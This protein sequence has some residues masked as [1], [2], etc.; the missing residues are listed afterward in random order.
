MAHSLPAR[1]ACAAPL[2]GG[3]ILIPGPGGRLQPLNDLLRRLRMLPR[4]CSPGENPLDGFGQ[5]QPT[6]PQRRVQRHDPVLPQPAEQLRRVMPRQVVPD[7]QHPQRRQLVQKRETEGEPVL[8][9]LPRGTDLLGGEI[10][11]RWRQRRQDLFELLLQPRVQDCIGCSLNPLDPNFSGRGMKEGPQLRRTPADVLVRVRERLPGGAPMTSR[12]R[13]RLVRPRLILVPLRQT[14]LGGEAVGGLNQYLFSPPRRSGSMT[15]TT[16]ALR[17]RSTRP[18][19][20]QERSFC[21]ESPAAC[22]TCPMV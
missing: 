10:G 8:P 3:R 18:V 1:P 11:W 13:N 16:P 7:Q 5:V 4:E 2:E 22:S 17:L 14:Q 9:A 12:L 21:Q 15:S 19:G 20:H 6:A